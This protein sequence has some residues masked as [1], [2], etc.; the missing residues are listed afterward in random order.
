MYPRLLQPPPKHN[1]FLFGPRGVGKTVWAHEQLPDALFFDLLDHQTYTQLLAAP[2]RLG[3][4]IP[5]S[6]KGWVVVERLPAP[7][8]SARTVARRTLAAGGD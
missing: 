4:R 2:Q 7:L 1:F 5:Q 3:D 6:H 8:P